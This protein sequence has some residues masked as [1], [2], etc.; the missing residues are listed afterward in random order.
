MDRFTHL[1]GDLGADIETLCVIKKIALRQ[2]IRMK[3]QI[4][5][6]LI[7]LVS[8]SCFGQIKYVTE[9]NE[10]IF[11]QPS[12]KLK[13]NDFIGDTTKELMDLCRKYN[14]TAISYADIWSILD[15]PKKKKDRKKKLEKV[16]FAPCFCKTA[17]FAISKDTMQIAIQ[18]VYFDIC[19]LAARWARRRLQNLQDSLKG[20]GILYIMYS[21]VEGEME[22][23]KTKMFMAYTKEV[24][25]DKKPGAFES[26][27]KFYDEMLEKTKQWATKPEECYRF[28]TTKPIEPGYEKSPMI[29]GDLRKKNN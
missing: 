10:H 11:W 23:Q 29:V 24:I 1:F 12:I 14:L 16:Y 27:R 17:S 3:K 8:I 2:S 22:E 15:V 4:I 13:Y 20:Y 9:D 19:E 25:Y 7:F 5:I 28:I 26:W 18:A 6:I 21:S